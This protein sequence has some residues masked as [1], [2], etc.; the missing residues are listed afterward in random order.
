MVGI[1]VVEEERVCQCTKVIGREDRLGKAMSSW[2]H[3]VHAARCE[4]LDR[5]LDVMQKVQDKELN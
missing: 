1:S 2:L 4:L 5:Q 3:I